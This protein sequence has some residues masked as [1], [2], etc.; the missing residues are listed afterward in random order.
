MSEGHR[1]LR[2]R[3]L[4]AF[5]LVA[6]LAV[7]SFAALI[8]WASGAELNDLVRRQQQ[9]TLHDAAAA[10][11]DAYREAGTSYRRTDDRARARAR[12]AGRAPHRHRPFGSDPASF[13][14][15]SGS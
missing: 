3:L 12:H 14:S 4:G 6:A 10:L 11:A 1:S 5:L 13:H 8:L 15:S 2:L 7:G 9:A